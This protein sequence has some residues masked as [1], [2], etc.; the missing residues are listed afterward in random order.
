MSPAGCICLRVNCTEREA[1]ELSKSLGS[2]KTSGIKAAGEYIRLCHNQHAACYAAFCLSDRPP[3]RLQI[4]L[5]GVC[6]Q[7]YVEEN[8]ILWGTNTWSIGFH[9]HKRHY[10]RTPNQKCL[11]N[12][13]HFETDS[14]KPFPHRI[15][16][17]AYDS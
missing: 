1:Y 4:D 6:R 15:S 8:P 17:T 13:V 12:K 14:I 9:F 10:I 11:I 7:A 5:L 2:E 3:N 16:V